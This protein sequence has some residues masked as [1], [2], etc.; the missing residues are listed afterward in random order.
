MFALLLPMVAQAAQRHEA[1]T[2]HVSANGTADGVL[3]ISVSAEAR[4]FLELLLRLEGYNVRAEATGSDASILDHVRSFAPVCVI[5]DEPPDGQFGAPGVVRA[6]RHADAGIG[7]LVLAADASRDHLEEI[8]DSNAFALVKPN[9]ADDLIAHVGRLFAERG[10]RVPS[11]TGRAAATATADE[12]PV[13]SIVIGDRPLADR[14]AGTLG[15]AGHHAVIHNAAESFLAAPATLR[16]A[17]R[18]PAGSPCRRRA[19]GAARAVAGRRS[20]G[21][22]RDQGQ[23]RRCGIRHAGGSR[24]CD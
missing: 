13:V 8:A 12:R 10:L 22:A 15:E 20:R 11:P 9:K 3:V 23:R 4:S 17:R 16:G 24:R 18:R 2:H 14:L 19:G 5:I 21:A 1:P 7:I 6:L